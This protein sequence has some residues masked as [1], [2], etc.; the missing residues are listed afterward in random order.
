MPTDR[1]GAGRGDAKG[2]TQRKAQGVAGLPSEG[3]TQRTEERD[4]HREE[5]TQAATQQEAMEKDGRRE[6][7]NPMSSAAVFTHIHTHTCIYTYT[8]AHIC[9]YTYIYTCSHTHIY[10]I[11]MH[12]HTLIHLHTRTHIYMHTAYTCIHIHTH[13]CLQTHTYTHTKM[14]TN[15]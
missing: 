14:H 7:G 8:H 6:K 15:T 5:V 9:I 4:R 10:Y 2:K 3:Q 12:T 11:Y 13:I 1:L